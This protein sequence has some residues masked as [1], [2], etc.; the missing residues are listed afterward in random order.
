MRGG[1]RWWLFWNPLWDEASV[2]IYSK[3]FPPW[4]L[5]CSNPGKA[6]QSPSVLLCWQTDWSGFS[7]IL[8]ISAVPISP[9]TVNLLVDQR[10]PPHHTPWL[11][12]PTESQNHIDCVGR[13]F[14]D[15]LVQLPLQWP[16]ISPTRPGYSEPHPTWISP[17][18][19]HLPPLWATYSRFLF[20]I[21]KDFFLVSNLSQL[22]FSLKQLP[23][24]L[25]QGQLS[26][27]G[28]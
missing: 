1:N 15:P 19:K 4:A 22:S 7:S 24:V 5:L 6:A 2:S 23:V 26:S 3:R 8:F 13:D 11:S 25:S 28:A 14:N 20:L 18:M 17:G 16:R 27:C 10:V 9:A 12:V 21:V